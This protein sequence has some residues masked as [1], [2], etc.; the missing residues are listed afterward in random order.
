M[1][2]YPNSLYLSTVRSFTTSSY[3]I[4]DE[5]FKNPRYIKLIHSNEIWKILYRET[6]DRCILNK[7]RTVLFIIK[8]AVLF[9][10]LPQIDREENN[11]KASEQFYA[12]I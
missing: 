4:I 5:R 12:N 9:E 8:H 10:E 3:Q 7:K 11:R 6:I 1:L 2:F